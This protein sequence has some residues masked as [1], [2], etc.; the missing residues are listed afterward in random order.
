M[1]RSCKQVIQIPK[2]LHSLTVLS[3]FKL[4]N[5][6]NQEV[7]L[8]RFNVRCNSREC[9]DRI[10]ECGNAKDFADLV[11]I[12]YGK[13]ICISFSTAGGIGEEHDKKI[14]N[15]LNDIINFIRA[16][17][18][19]RNDEW[20]P[21]FQPLPLFSRRTEEQIEEEGANEEMEA[22]MNNNGYNRRIKY[23]AKYAKA[24]ILN[25]FIITI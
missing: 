7:D 16:L 3:S 14:L 15:V 20:Q 21:S 8:Q 6:S 4:G 9:L 24:V 12:G 23:Y 18:N 22:Q 10:Q 17:H 2:F 19:G 25:H 11:N 5:H 1:N 13:V